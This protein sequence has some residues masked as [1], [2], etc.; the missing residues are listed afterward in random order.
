MII[1]IDANAL[2]REKFT[3]TERY[4]LELLRAMQ[5][6]PLES[7]EQ[8]HLYVSRPLQEF[9]N[10]PAGWKQVV[11]KWP[12]KKIWTHARLS[13]RLLISPPDIF[14]SPAHEI[15]LLHR[16]CKIIT[17][18]HDIAFRIMPEVYSEK[19][20]K[21]QEWAVGRAILQSK[22]IL[23]VSNTTKKDLINYYRAAEAVICPTPLGIHPERLQVKSED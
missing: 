22:K 11:L 7:G 10:L 20:R 1:G 9:K 21:R 16:R 12:P 14:F 2:A 15:P 17:T 5:E 19:N 23:T 13:L 18:I 4:V 3:G 6:Q 8:V